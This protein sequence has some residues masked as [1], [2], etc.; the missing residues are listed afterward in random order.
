MVAHC[1]PC[2]DAGLAGRG[3]GPAAAGGAERLGGEGAGHR[4]ALHDRD[5]EPAGHR[6]RCRCAGARRQCRRCHGGGAVRVEPGG[7]SVVGHR[8]R[9]VHAPLGCEGEAAHHLR[10]ARNR[11]NCRRP[12]PVPSAGRHGHAVRR[13]RCG[14]KIGRDA[15]H[16]G[17]DR[18]GASAAWPLAVGRP[19]HPGGGPCREG[20]RDFSA[21]GGRHCRQCRQDLGLPG[22]TSLF[23]RR[24]R[25][26]TRGG[27]L[28]PESGIW[29]NS[30]SDR[31]RRQRT[32]LPRSH[33]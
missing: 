27:E 20:N 4:P 7:A 18:A 16:A 26:T 24:G 30:A 9:R 15:G 31:R 23:P 22:D 19:G 14:R 12:G 13:G 3:A 25:R 21:I 10:R 5:R 17:A 1:H 2:A 11:A 32:S 33:R 29:R 28:A 6:C 8:R